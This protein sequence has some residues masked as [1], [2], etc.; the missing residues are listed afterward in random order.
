MKKSYDSKFKGHLALEALR[1]ELTVA[2][3]A[4]KYRVH[5]NQVQQW[6][7]KLM[8]RASGI[9]QS[10]ANQGRQFTSPEFV[11][12]LQAHGIRTSIDGGDG[13]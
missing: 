7:K 3:I 6:K 8:K 5:L 9:F 11:A 13:I 12:E 10:K 4:G 2:E 1:R